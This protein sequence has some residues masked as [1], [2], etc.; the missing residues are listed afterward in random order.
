MHVAER[1][2]GFIFQ[3]HNQGAWWSNLLDDPQNS[4]LL[5]D[6]QTC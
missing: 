1:V 2:K 4:V 6:I 5:T 3:Q